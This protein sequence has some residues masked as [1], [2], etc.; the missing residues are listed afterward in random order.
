M[1]TYS[2]IKR[3]RFLWAALLLA[4]V[5]TVILVA[6][7]GQ[8]TTAT[9]TATTA[10][11]QAPTATPT[12]AASPTPVAIVKVKIVEKNGRYSFQPATLTVKAGTQVIWTNASDAPHTVTSDTNAFTASNDITQNQTFMMIFATPGTFKYHCSIHTYM[13]ATITVTS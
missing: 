13:I 2:S 5:L 4:A 9:P 12:P 3:T 11:T 7:G 6:C 1:R 10:P 8:T